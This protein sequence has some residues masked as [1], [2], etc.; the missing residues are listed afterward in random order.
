MKSGVTRQDGEAL[1][2]K[3][4]AAGATAEVRGDTAPAP[5]A[6]TAPAMAD[7]KYSVRLETSGSAKIQ[8]IKVVKENLGLGLKDAK[9]LVERAPVDVKQG[10]SKEAAEKLAKQLNDVGGT[11][12]VRVAGD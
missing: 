11:A 6:A 1:V 10:L 2:K 4:G 9:E 7:G 3:L 8:C 12:K 5:A